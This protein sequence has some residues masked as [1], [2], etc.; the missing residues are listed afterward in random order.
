M[1]KLEDVIGIKFGSDTTIVEGKLNGNIVWPFGNPNILD[2]SVDKDFNKPWITRYSFNGNNY[3]SL[4][5]V[6]MQENYSDSGEIYSLLTFRAGDGT[7]WVPD[8][9]NYKTSIFYL[10]IKPKQACKLRFT[11]VNINPIRGNSTD[12]T[13]FTIEVGGSDIY[14]KYGVYQN[15]YSYFLTFDL[16]YDF[17]ANTEKLITITSK[18]YYRQYSHLQYFALKSIE[19]VYI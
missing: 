15:S 8:G 12:P 16:D 19:I 1:S 3:P 10:R 7:S 17:V 6:L 4:E 18:T 14:K 5:S 13:E 11:L 9:T 2:F